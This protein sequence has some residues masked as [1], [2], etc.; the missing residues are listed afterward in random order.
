VIHSRSSCFGP[1]WLVVLTPHLLYAQRHDTIHNIIVI[2]L[3][4]LDGLLP[5]DIRLS[6]DELNVFG[7][8][9]SVVDFLSIV[10]IVFYLLLLTTFDSLASST[11][12]TVIVSSMVIGRLLGELLC[13]RGL[14]LGVQI[15]DLSFAED[16]TLH[17]QYI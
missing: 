5:A 3:E 10:V 2:L 9:A 7:L 16:A 8:Q 4:R 15:L 14:G 11:L 6:H 1:C 13:S 12:S 17:R